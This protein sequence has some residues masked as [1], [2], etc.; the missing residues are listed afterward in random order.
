[1]A[2][3][4]NTYYGKL[5]IDGCCVGTIKSVGD[6]MVTPACYSPVNIR[7][8]NVLVEDKVV[9]VT[10]SGGKKQK[11]VCAEGDKFDLETAISIC[12]TKHLLGG[13]KAYNDAI[14]YGMRVY[15]NKQKKIEEE[16]KL[17]ELI[18][19]KREKRLAKMKKRAEKKREEAIAIQTEA[20]IRAMKAM[21]EEGAE[22]NA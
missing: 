1:M 3:E 11:A 12:I 22:N 14:K 2:Y 6:L 7:D 10:F 9:E 5:F 15:N 17:Q 21:K 19:R 13:T 16:K 8:V 20:Y 4:G 18:A